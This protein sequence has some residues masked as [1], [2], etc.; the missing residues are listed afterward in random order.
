MSAL[1]FKTIFAQKF[2]SFFTAVSIVS[3]LTNLT[4][5]NATFA[6]EAAISESQLVT[7]LRAAKVVPAD[8]KLSASIAGDEVVITTTK[9]EGATGDASKIEAVLIAKTVFDSVSNDQQRTKVIFFDF[10]AN[11]YSE[12]AV[13]RAEVKMYGS[14]QLT[15]KELL[16][17]LE[18]KTGEADSAEDET[19]KVGPGP[20]QP[21][22]ILLSARLLKLENEGSSVKDLRQL[23][24]KLEATAKS[25][26][27]NETLSQLRA[28]KANVTERE[29][30]LDEARKH[31]SFLSS[32]AQQTLVKSN[33]S[34]EAQQKSGPLNHTNNAPG[35]SGGFGKDYV[36]GL[37]LNPGTG[38]NMYR[39]GVGD[40]P[41][42]HEGFGRLLFF[43]AEIQKRAK[44]GQNVQGLITIMNSAVYSHKTNDINQYQACMRDLFGQLGQPAKG[45]PGTNNTSGHL[46]QPSF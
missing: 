29:K 28:L 20:L 6:A 27:R 43:L 21:D 18:L 22:R 7:I 12:V 35:N 33:Q 2:C 17:S 44:F 11:S 45:P 3:V 34:N 41:Q 13:K 19:V 25:G 4:P 10:K 32:K 37:L 23:F 5:T 46:P 42:K 14:G 24:D 36:S 38:Q 9:K 8:S 16:S 30:A 31:E 1:L 15:E 39:F 40:L 26:D